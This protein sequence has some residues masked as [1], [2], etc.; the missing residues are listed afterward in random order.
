MAGREQLAVFCYD[1]SRDS[2]RNRIAAVLERFGT[3]VQFSV[4]ECRLKASKAEAVSSTLDVMR[5]PGDSVRMYVVP[6]DGRRASR[7]AGGA[8]IAERSGVLL[9]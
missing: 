6:E 8:P 2:T 4:F 3:R 9:F 1:V 7:A 5:D